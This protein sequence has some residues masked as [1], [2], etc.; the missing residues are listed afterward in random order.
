MC[1]I[2]LR[3][4]DPAALRE[5]VRS[6]PDHPTRQR[7]LILLLLSA[8]VPWAAVTA[9]LGC[10]PATVARWAGRYR[11]GGV[12]ALSARP[13]RHPRL[14]YWAAVLV[15]WVLARRPADFGFARSRW[16]C[17]AV[18]VVLREDYRVRA[19]R[20]TVRRCLTAAGL[21]WR[22]PRPVARRHDP[23]RA[24]KLTALRQLLRELPADETAVFMD[25]VEVHTNPKVGSMWMRRGEQATV[26]APGDNEKR[27]LAGGLHWRTG[28]LVETWGGEG[29][30]RTAGLFCRHL[31]DLRRAFRHYRVIHV[32]CDHA[33]NHRPDKST[34]VKKYLAAWGERVVV[35]YLPKYA[36]DTNPVEEV[37]WRL[38]EAVTRNHRCRSMHELVELTMNWL[39]ERRF[40]RVARDAYNAPEPQRL[41][42]RKGAI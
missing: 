7:A 9:A 6:A 8:G 40:F 41:S 1:S 12:A 29:E 35:H 27:V 4:D 28:R 39:D 3:P 18:A 14:A 32:I 16:S 30:G 38:H 24:A 34:A 22:R 23:D 5:L 10:S 42:P 13:H 36:P 2:T 15:G 11:A 33:F 25:E 20:E 21:V 31:D 19:G 26:E 37:W 17:E